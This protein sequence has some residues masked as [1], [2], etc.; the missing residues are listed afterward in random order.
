MQKSLFMK[1]SIDRINYRKVITVYKCLNDFAPDMIHART[2]I[3]SSRNDLY[4]PPG[5]H[6]EVFNCKRLFVFFLVFRR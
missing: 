5:K 3:S 2:T 1:R 4:L 6:K